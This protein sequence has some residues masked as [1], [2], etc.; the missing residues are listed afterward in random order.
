MIAPTLLAR[1]IERR[2]LTVKWIAGL[3]SWAFELI[4]AV[5]GETEVVDQ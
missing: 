4:T 1:M 2:N 5:A 3:Y